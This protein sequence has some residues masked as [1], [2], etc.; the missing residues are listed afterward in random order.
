MYSP[1]QFPDVFAVNFEGIYCGISSDIQMVVAEV[2]T[3]RRTC[4]ND[5][6]IE[7]RRSPSRLKID[8]VPDL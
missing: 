2:H 5:Q 3:H 4:G 7:G 6:S 1:I 8:T